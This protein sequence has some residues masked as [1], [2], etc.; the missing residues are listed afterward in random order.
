[1]NYRSRTLL[2][3]TFAALLLGVYA[4]T[5]QPVQADTKA[6]VYMLDIGQGDSFLIVAANGK[7]L[8]ID[9]GKDSSVLSE[10]SAVM[11][12]GDRTIDVMIATHPDADHIG[13]LPSV[14]GRYDVGLFLTSQVYGSSDMY[15]SL[16]K[17]LADKKIPSYYV[18]RGMSLKLDTNEIIPSTFSIL[19]P[20]RPTTNW[21]T[22]TASVVGRLDMG[23][24]SMLLNGDSPSSIERY[25]V[26]K[27]PKILDVDILKLGH[28]GSKTSSSEE[29][30]R[31]TSPLLA[32][33]S[34]GARN[35]YGHP[36]PEVVAR[37]K[38]LRIPSTST[39]D[40]GIVTLTTDGNKWVE[41]DEK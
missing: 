15:K 2:L 30:L 13:G 34:A 28:H 16:L 18:R 26:Q 41:K 23:T 27:D 22:N 5:L 8:L 7:K 9:G 19:F 40:H 37:L 21:E 29:Y 14:L 39:I 38:S 6:R 4:Y 24:S 35:T 3:M 11:P 12:T 31:A 32:L 33:I 1:M 36:A 10:L 20:D 25:M 17:T